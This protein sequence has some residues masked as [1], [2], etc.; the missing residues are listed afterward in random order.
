MAYTI[1]QT[2]GKH[3]TSAWLI[4]MP[5]DSDHAVPGDQGAHT[6]YTV[7]SVQIVSTL[8]DD[9]R[10]LIGAGAIA[11]HAAREAGLI[12]QVQQHLATATK[13]ACGEV[14]ALA[15]PAPKLPRELTVTASRFPDRVQ[16]TVEL[17]IAA[18]NAEAPSDSTKAAPG[19]GKRG[20]KLVEGGLVDHVE[21]ETHD[22]RPAMVLVKYYRPVKSKA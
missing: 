19:D 3:A 1:A 15:H 5:T 11:A 17:S 12:E 14:F 16:I 21:W 18:T 9:P 13:E 6:G 7:P 20:R 4:L 2:A 10:L 22:G 8:D